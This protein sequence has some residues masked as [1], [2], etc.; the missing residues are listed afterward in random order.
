VE[1]SK[2]G[3]R[4]KVIGFCSRPSLDLLEKCGDIKNGLSIRILNN[5]YVICKDMSAYKRITLRIT[6]SINKEG[7]YGLCAIPGIGPS[8]A[9]EIIKEREKRGGF[10]SLDELLSVH[11]IGT[12][13]YRKIT[14]Y[15]SL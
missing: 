10:K 2:E 12:K 3:T 5:G 7:V 4:A 15:I 14:P 11:G 9:K 8:I 1:I 6:I 13:L